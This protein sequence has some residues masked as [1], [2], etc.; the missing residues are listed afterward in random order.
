MNASD[1]RKTT[2]KYLDNKLKE[3]KDKYKS[4]TEIA[5]RFLELIRM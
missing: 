5:N 1:Q 2:K 4:Q 3:I